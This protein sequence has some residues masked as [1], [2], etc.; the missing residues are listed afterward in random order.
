MIF[1]IEDNGRGF[2]TAILSSVERS[3]EKAVYKGFGI[4]NAIRRLKLIYRD[5]CNVTIQRQ[6]GDWNKSY[7]RN[8]G[9]DFAGNKAVVQ[10][11][12]PDH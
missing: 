5:Q 11:N 10:T 8:T 4:K 3:D 12:T 6:A 9:T 1:V 7:Y 2:D